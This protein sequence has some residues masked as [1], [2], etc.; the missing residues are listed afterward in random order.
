MK[1]NPFTSSAGAMPFLLQIDTKQGVRARKPARPF[2]ALP[3]ESEDAR[4]TGQTRSL[5]RRLLGLN[6][7]P[8][9][10]NRPMARIA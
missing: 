10:A 2:T 9:L 4:I 8:F 6:L 3:V 5:H 1:S 7:T